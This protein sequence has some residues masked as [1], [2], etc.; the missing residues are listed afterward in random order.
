[1]VQ[2][3]QNSAVTIRA[4]TES[5]GGI[6]PELLKE[7]GSKVL[8]KVDNKVERGYLFCFGFVEPLPRVRGS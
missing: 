6:G 4:I 1:M 5:R 7:R 8:E 2:L 3:G